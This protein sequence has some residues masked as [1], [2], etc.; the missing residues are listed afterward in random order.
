[1][2]C[3]SEI[4]SFRDLWLLPS[5][6]LFSWLMYLILFFPPKGTNLFSLVVNSFLHNI[7]ILHLLSS[8]LWQ[9]FTEI[10][11]QLSLSFFLFLFYTLQKKALPVLLSRLP[12]SLWETQSQ[13][14]GH[15]N[16]RCSMKG[17]LFYLSQFWEKP[18]LQNSQTSHNLNS[19]QAAQNQKGLRTIFRVGLG[20]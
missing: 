20:R 19:L 14:T 16:G 10:Q 6:L 3:I 2:K 15:K 7:R 8:L 11:L 18:N 9:N 1:M 13:V 5:F 12:H 17:Q 4:R